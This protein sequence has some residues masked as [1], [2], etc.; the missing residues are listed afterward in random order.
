[1]F[2]EGHTG[3]GAS[4][5]GEEFADHIMSLWCADCAERFG[6]FV[7]VMQSAVG[8]V[9]GWWGEKL[10][11]QKGVRLF[12]GWGWQISGDGARDRDNRG[13]EASDKGAAWKFQTNKVRRRVNR[14]S[15][16]SAEEGN[17]D[18]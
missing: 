11:Y 9:V 15:F 2:A 8:L 1:M 17:D 7:I 4:Q 3:E 14:L 13:A 18:C 12:R 5:G 16:R 6:A 10:P